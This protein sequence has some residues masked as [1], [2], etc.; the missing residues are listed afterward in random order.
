MSMGDR[1]RFP[2]DDAYVTALGRAT[3]VFATLEWNA[4]WCAE[5]LDRDF[6]N[7][8]GIK[9][10]GQIAGGLITLIGKVTDPALR[11]ACQPPATEF[12]RLA[13]LRNGILH[14]KPGTASGGAQ[15]LFRNGNPWTPEAIDDAADEFAACSILLNS[16]LYKE[17]AAIP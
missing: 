4:V 5:R 3:Y 13:K 2:V 15:C 7:N 17:L 6:I 11:A 9:T 16:L 12:S 1:L 14:G 10:A 8:L